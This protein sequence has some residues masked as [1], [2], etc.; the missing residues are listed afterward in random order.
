MTEAH[1]YV[2]S[3]LTTMVRN[4]EQV[5]GLAGAVAG[6]LAAGGGERGPDLA[7]LIAGSA[8]M[9]APKRAPRTIDEPAAEKAPQVEQRRE[10]AV[11]QVMGEEIT[12]RAAPGERIR[13]S[14]RVGAVGAGGGALFLTDRRLVF[15]AASFK[16]EAR[17]FEWNIK[18]IKSFEKT[19]FLTSNILFTTTTGTQ[20]FVFYDRDIWMNKLSYPNDD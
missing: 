8:R 5:P 7:E 14:A 17:R 13:H 10:E 18:D 1:E 9:P 19:G 12:L 15:R 4:R 20:E 6:P 11:V 16:Q 2:A 3:V